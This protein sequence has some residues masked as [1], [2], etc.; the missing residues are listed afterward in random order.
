MYVGFKIIEPTLN[1]GLDFKD[2][3]EMALEV[4]NSSIH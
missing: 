3:C 4:H 2:A 1:T